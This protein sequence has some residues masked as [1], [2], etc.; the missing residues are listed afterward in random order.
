MRL[1]TLLAGQ[2]ERK[3]WSHPDIVGA[4]EALRNVAADVVIANDLETLPLALSLRGSPKVIFDAH[5]YKPREFEDRAVFRLWQRYHW[6]LWR[7][8]VP[9]ADAVTTVSPGLVEAFRSDLGVAPTLIT[10]ATAF[11]DLEPTPLHTPIR[12][13]HHGYAIVSRNLELTLE[14]AALL[15]DR[16]SLDLLLLPSSQ[17]YLEKLAAQAEGIPNVRMRAPVSPRD[18]ASE[19]NDNDMGVFLL[20]P[21]NYN[22]RHAL[23]NKLFEFVQAR[24]GV[25]IG[26]SPDMAAIVT[27]HEL[28]IVADDF[29]PHA[30]ARAISGLS[31]EDITRMKRHSHAAARTLSAEQNDERLRALV[32]RLEGA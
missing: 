20:P 9:R 29:T 26:P 16:F 21:V 22:Y 15:G 5:E 10:N 14:M 7:T 12:L 4:A 19:T 3:Y 13:V 28:G 31:A 24:L 1:L 17:G 2:H 27:E 30:M 8:Y 23:P 32:S 25:A 11:H 6:F 18:L